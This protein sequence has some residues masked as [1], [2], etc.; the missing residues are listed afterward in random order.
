MVASKD[1]FSDV[2]NRQESE[3][4]DSLY[5]S[6]AKGAMA[7]GGTLLTHQN[8]NAVD[9]SGAT[10]DNSKAPS[11][12]QRRDEESGAGSY[13]VTQMQ[14]M[15]HSSSSMTKLL[16][17]GRPPK[18]EEKERHMVT[19]NPISLSR[20]A[21][22]SRE[23]SAASLAT[24]SQT[25]SKDSLLITGSQFT[26]GKSTALRVAPKSAPKPRQIIELPTQKK[27]VRSKVRERPATLHRPVTTQSNFPVKR[28]SESSG[29]SMDLSPDAMDITKNIVLAEVD[30]QIYN[31]VRTDSDH[32]QRKISTMASRE[33]DGGLRRMLSDVVEEN[34]MSQSW[35][36]IGTASSDKGPR[37]ALMED[38]IPPQSE[39]SAEN[40]EAVVV[41]V[42]SI[43]QNMDDSQNLLSTVAL[44]EQRKEYVARGD[45]ETNKEPGAAEVSGDA[46]DAGTEPKNSSSR[47][48][49]NLP[50][51]SAPIQVPEESL[52]VES[53]QSRNEQASV[54]TKE[55]DSPKKTVDL[56]QLLNPDNIIPQLSVRRQHS[57]NLQL[58]TIQRQN[59]DNS[60]HSNSDR[61][62]SPSVMRRN[63]DNV[64]PQ[65]ILQRQ[66]S[67]GSQHQNQN[68][69]KINSSQ[70]NKKGKATTKGKGKTA[71]SSEKQKD[72]RQ[73]PLNTV[74]ATAED[75][76]EANG[77]NS[78]T[79]DVSAPTSV[80]DAPH[81]V[82]TDYE[83]L[84]ASIEST[85]TATE[86][87]R[88]H[89][90]SSPLDFLKP[91]SDTSA[92]KGMY[93]Y[94]TRIDNIQSIAYDETQESR[95]TKSDL[96]SSLDAMLNM[97]RNMLQKKSDEMDKRIDDAESRQT[98]CLHSVTHTIDAVRELGLEVSGISDVQRIMLAKMDS[99]SN[100]FQQSL[101]N[102]D[103]KVEACNNRIAKV[104]ERS[105]RRE[106]RII[107][108][109]ER[110]FSRI[111]LEGERVV[112]WKPL[113]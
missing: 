82:N 13:D 34:D 91:I 105:V 68:S 77:I 94:Y 5:P 14:D 21:L 113:P 72:M 111:R 62:Q 3:Y 17:S 92:P 54:A 9:V 33:K 35:L 22:I 106:K 95:L 85:P 51:T 100:Q 18:A 10:A 79:L 60:Q 24:S 38:I 76:A 104:D 83:A 80:Y 56:L 44:D 78:L 11:E 53:Y 31:S 25:A 23:S 26:L 19:N 52:H 86:P 43:E 4:V 66:N 36:D 87:R 50:S 16:A 84:F 39:D 7:V 90:L 29:G 46:S 15:S 48:I 6:R 74:G 70:G 47:S 81:T 65:N 103:G 20:A 69:E 110:G 93:S 107:A 30:A 55:A 97:M 73:M 108:R 67:D 2:I 99:T 27:D 98:L 109:M 58:P 42:V 89:L 63:S 102:V 28:N 37:A 12:E 96:Q 8:A 1:G 57:D 45:H 101:N 71:S 75:K 112:S 61:Q 59:S 64:D 40:E 41:T 49:V 32:S 88:D